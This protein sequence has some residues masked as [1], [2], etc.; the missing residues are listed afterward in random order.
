MAGIAALRQVQMQCSSPG[1]HM[2]S[3]RSATTTRIHRAG[4]SGKDTSHWDGGCW[5]PVSSCTVRHSS[6]T[7]NNTELSPT[8]IGTLGQRWRWAVLTWTATDVSPKH[9]DS[10]ALVQLQCVPSWHLG[11]SVGRCW[12]LYAPPAPSKVAWPWARSFTRKMPAGILL[13]PLTGT[14]LFPIHT[15]FLTIQMPFIQS[16]R[17]VGQLSE[18]FSQTAQ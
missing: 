16:P 18:M 2:L 10:A 17:C 4:G 14:A 9:S 8:P 6:V 5:A 12:Q 3:H 1:C 7:G 15:I 13:P 11:S